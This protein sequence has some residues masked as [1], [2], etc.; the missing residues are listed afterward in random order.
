V[1]ILFGIGLLVV[2]VALLWVMA[3][4][5]FLLG[6]E[7]GAADAIGPRCGKCGYGV[8]GLPTTTCPECGS[9]LREV[10]IV[11]PGVRSTLGPG[12]R[13]ALWT[14]ALAL[15][16]FPLSALLVGMVPVWRDYYMQR[17]I[18][19]QDKHLN[20]TV[21]VTADSGGFGRGDA[22]EVPPPPWRLALI[23]EARGGPLYV[24]DPAPG[25]EFVYYRSTDGQIVR[26]RGFGPEAVLAWMRDKQTVGNVPAEEVNARAADVFTCLRE[27][28]NA[29]GH[30]TKLGRDADH[31][32][33]PVT[34]HPTTVMSSVS[35]WSWAVIVVLWAAVWW[36]VAR[37]M[38]WKRQ[39]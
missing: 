15:V 18:F 24:R 34:A 11:T 4:R 29:R 22:A 14:I 5:V 26:G 3:R 16:A 31:M 21:R 19:V 38:R 8:R 6:A 23:D 9:D 39:P 1:R 25:G 10:G 7:H 27:M 32:L 35:P 2:V 33:D 17:V 30:F 28:P 37:R 36:V 20:A 13:L 12:M